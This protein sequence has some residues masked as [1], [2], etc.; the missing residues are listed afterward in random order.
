MVCS[1]CY[2]RCIVRFYSLE[3]VVG[4]VFVVDY[5]FF[6]LKDDFGGFVME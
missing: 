6:S 1:G 2:F 5:I 4:Q 3:Q